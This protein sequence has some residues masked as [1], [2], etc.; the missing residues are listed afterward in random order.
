MEEEKESPT[1]LSQQVRDFSN[2]LSDGYR[3]IFGKQWPPWLGGL[4]LGLVAFAMFAYVSAWYI[5]DGFTV[6]GDLVINALGIETA[7]GTVETPWDSYGWIHIVGIIGGA[8][9]SCLLASDFRIRFPTRRIRLVEGLVGGVIMGVGAMLAPGCN[10][11]GYFSAIASLSASGFVMVF[12]LGSGAYTGVLLAR[13]RLKRELAAGMIKAQ[14]RLPTTSKPAEKKEPTRDLQPLMGLGVLVFSLIAY[15]IFITSDRITLGAYLLFG[16]VFG[17]I[18]QRAG[19]CVTASFRELF[20]T[21]GGGLA[22]G[23]IVTMVIAMLGF[24]IL[25]ER[26]IRDPYVLPLGWRTFAGGYIFGLGMVIAGGCATGTLFR[27]GEGNVQLMLAFV[28]AA[29]SAS[30]T[31]AYLVRTEFSNGENVWVVDSMGWPG[32]IAATLIF[33]FLFYLVVQFNEMRRKVIL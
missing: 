33:L 4:L 3:K 30:L 8:F 13:W 16:L 23:M 31:N 21:G 14:I 18:L 25:I 1:V 32:A 27:I 26:G 22:R 28:G 6:S 19:F 9:A 15:F 12:A 29:I 20:T 7:S 24:S 17:V 11:G 2:Y 5:Y 10:I